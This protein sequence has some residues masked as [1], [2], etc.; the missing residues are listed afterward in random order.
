[1]SDRERRDTG[2]TGGAAETKG[3]HRTAETVEVRQQEII[4]SIRQRQ[5]GSL[6]RRLINTLKSLFQ[7]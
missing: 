2:G 1:M 3:G 4:H 7:S 5:Q 6:F